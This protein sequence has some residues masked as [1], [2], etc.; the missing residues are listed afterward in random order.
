MMM[1]SFFFDFPAGTASAAS[2]GSAGAAGLA[3]DTVPW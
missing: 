2:S 1:N 3:I